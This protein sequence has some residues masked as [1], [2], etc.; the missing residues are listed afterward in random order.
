MRYKTQDPQLHT[1]NHGGDIGIY[2]FKRSVA[3]IEEF[4]SGEHGYDKD[5]SNPV[6]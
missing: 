1:R 2:D 6:L 5:G 4:E 3:L